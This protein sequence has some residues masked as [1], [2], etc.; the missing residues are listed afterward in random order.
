MSR[1]PRLMRGLWLLCFAAVHAMPLP[2][3]ATAKPMRVAIYPLLN[4]GVDDGVATSLL[5]IL[6]AE[7]AQLP[8]VSVL[9]R[10]KAGRLAGGDC[11]GDAKCLAAAGAKLG[12]DEVV[13]G[14]V[15]GV[16]EAY[17]VDLKR[18]GVHSAREEAR[19]TET[20][21][22]AHEL[23]IDTVRAAAY[24]LLLPDQFVG[25]VE[26]DIAEPGVEIFLDGKSA[27]KSP[28]R[29]PIPNVAPGKHAVKIVKVGFA[30]FDRF[31]DV[32]F[33]RTTVVR[34]DLRNN[35]TTGV[36]A[37]KPG[38]APEVAGGERAALVPL[39]PPLPPPPE[40]AATGEVESEASSSW[41][42]Q[43]KVAAWTAGGGAVVLIAAGIVGVSSASDRNKAIAG[44][45][46]LDGAKGPV[47]TEAA[48]A[49][50]RSSRDKAVVANVLFG[51]GGVVLVTSAVLYLTGGPRTGEPRLAPAVAVIDRGAVL[52]VAGRF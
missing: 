16:G 31:V 8:G 39:H 21:S 45:L 17:S 6:R 36:M 34:V 41:T 25:K 52:G 19:V 48:A 2:A 30:D 7:V 40:L 22:G 14:T 9:G 50:V 24:K 43:R 5:D 49:L 42:G 29:A 38:A 28:L 32:K 13:W 11:K 20:L 4:L 33:A 44:Q 3:R 51:A 37:S 15:A 23:L 27:G 12:A 35:V 46:T 26:V 1:L 10:P 47:T 18:V